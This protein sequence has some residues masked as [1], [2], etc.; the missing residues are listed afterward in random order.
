MSIYTDKIATLNQSIA[1]MEANAEI[2]RQLINTKQQALDVLN[3]KIEQARNK[4]AGLNELE[5]GN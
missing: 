4:I 3:T 1:T 5:T 2:L